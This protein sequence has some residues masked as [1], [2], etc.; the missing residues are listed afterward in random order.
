M[1][2]DIIYNIEAEKL[3]CCCIASFN[4]DEFETY[5]DQGLCVEMF[6]DANHR[7]IIAAGL[8]YYSDS[9]VSFFTSFLLKY[10][11]NAYQYLNKELV[12]F[13]SFISIADTFAILKQLYKKRILQAAVYRVAE[14]IINNE[15][16]ETIETM[17]N[18]VDSQNDDD[19]NKNYI[20]EKGTLFA[21]R[22]N[23]IHNPIA[24]RFVLTAMN[25]IDNGI[26][27]FKGNEFII[28]AGRPGTGKSALALN[29]AVGASIVHKN[30]TLFFSLEMS[31]QKLMDRVIAMS[32]EV[33]SN[34][35]ERCKGYQGEGTKVRDAIKML[36][37][38][39]DLTIVDKATMT[40][41]LIKSII[42]KINKKKPVDM[43]IIDYLQLITPEDTKIIREQQVS[44]ISR[45]LKL[46]AKDMKI[47][48]ICLAQLNRDSSKEKRRP[49][50]YDL[51]ES[52]S[53]EQD[54]DII[55]LLSN[56]DLKAN[57]KDPM[58]EVLIDFAKTREYGVFEFTKKFAKNIQ[59][60]I[61]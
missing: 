3:F 43:V 49:A 42:R 39:L 57:L 4:R 50:V 2:K 48:V 17:R 46:I 32:S 23:E 7:I 27:G 1:K 30:H 25:E 31:A 22:L 37:D 40:V 21:D 10:N 61:D 24:E 45:S 16:D 13:T 41:S 28:M 29:L 52:G 15:V 33:P 26:N 38:K 56:K 34:R 19:Q 58:P 35:I 44:N 12:N 59:K 18:I 11:N 5:I 36:D 47:P 54:A 53:L 14:N 51:R 60:F 6:T 20:Y 9:A 55:I 8:A